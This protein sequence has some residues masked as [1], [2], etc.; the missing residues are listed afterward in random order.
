MSDDFDFEKFWLGKFSQCLDSVAGSKIREKI[1]DGSENLSDNSSR[2]DII[3]WSNKAIGK[4]KSLIDEESIINII[5][6]S[7]CQ[8]PKSQ[9]QNIRK[10]YEE[11]KDIGLAHQKL[12]EHF[13]LFLRSP[14]L[15][16]NEKIIKEIIK[17]GWGLAG[18][19]ERNKI[20]AVK[21]PKSGFLKEYF[22][23]SNQNKKRQLY[24]HCPRINSQK[25][26]IPD[27]IDDPE[28]FCYCGAGFYKGIWQEIIQQDVKVEVLESVLK[29][30]DICK[31]SIDLHMDLKKNIN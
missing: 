23:T 24:C 3:S 12:Q 16:L 6:G 18:R 27:N 29:G 9:L 25:F 10:K 30:D 5:T 17:K 13:E 28:L 7:A 15:G 2:S 20:I 26:G 14:D 31:V 11:T 19:W 21:I 22:K 8:Y 4:L 1:I